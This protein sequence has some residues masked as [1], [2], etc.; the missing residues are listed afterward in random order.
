MATQKPYVIFLVDDDQVFAKTLELHL[1]EHLNIK[2]EIYT[3]SSGEDC[4]SN[5]EMKPAIVILDYFLNSQN[6]NAQNGLEILKKIKVLDPEI[7]VIM[8]SVQDKIQV[9]VNSMIYG[10]YNYLTKNDVAFFRVQNTITNIIKVIQSR[11]EIKS[12][13]KGE[14]MVYVIIGIIAAVACTVYYF[15]PFV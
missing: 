4:L 11:Q 13:K 7:E 3:F 15:Y 1:K 14:I 2:F 5:L 10:A 8:L 12:V 6:P 9:A